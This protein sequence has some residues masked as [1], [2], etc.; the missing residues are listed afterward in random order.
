MTEIAT[1]LRP[2]VLLPNGEAARP[3]EVR[4]VLIEPAPALHRA[5]GVRLVFPEIR[6]CGAAFEAGQFFVRACG[7]KD[8]SADRRLAC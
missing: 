2:L 7:V 1:P 5:L 6:R 8:S 3:E 4:R